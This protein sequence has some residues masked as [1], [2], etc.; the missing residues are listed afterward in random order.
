MNLIELQQARARNGLRAARLATVASGLGLFIWG[1]V[2]AVWMRLHGEE[3]S[4]TATLTNGGPVFLIAGLFL[5]LAAC[6]G[7]RD[8]P[9]WAA[10]WLAVVLVALPVLTAWLAQAFSRLA[11]FPL[12]LATL[13]AF[14]CGGALV[15]RQTCRV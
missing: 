1:L 3:V 7:R 8:W 5:L 10:L 6:M 14:T 11:L 9:L 15:V 13:T 2:P 4:A 12:F